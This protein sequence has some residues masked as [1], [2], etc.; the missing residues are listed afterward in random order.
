MT[1]VADFE[2]ENPNYYFWEKI[3]SVGLRAAKV[4]GAV[5]GVA[6]GF[7]LIV[8]RV[9]VAAE[10]DKYTLPNMVKTLDETDPN[11]VIKH[12]SDE[13]YYLGR[14]RISKAGEKCTA[15]FYL[16]ESDQG[17]INATA[18]GSS[19]V[20][21][22]KESDYLIKVAGDPAFIEQSFEEYRQNQC[23]SSN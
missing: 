6:L 21:I 19:S 4:V 1:D 13:N 5:G 12:E 17:E 15:V 8:N 10:R 7:G 3:K 16:S 18:S 2:S 20:P 14:L 11:I 9:Q 23:K 22:A